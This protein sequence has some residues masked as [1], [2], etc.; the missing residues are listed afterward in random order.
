[1]RPFNGKSQIYP[2]GG[3]RNTVTPGV[4]GAPETVVGGIHD[5]YDTSAVGERSLWTNIGGV[6]NP[7]VWLDFY[8]PYTYSKNTF[9]T[10]RGWMRDPSAYQQYVT[11][12]NIAY[13]SNPGYINAYYGYVHTMAGYN[14]GTSFS[15]G[16]M[17]RANSVV[18]Y[19]SLIGNGWPGGSNYGFEMRR[20]DSG[21]FIMMRLFNVMDSGINI[22]TGPWYYISWTY[23]G[24]VAKAWLNG[25][26][27]FSINATAGIR[28]SNAPVY[29]GFNDNDERWSGDIG[30]LYIGPYVSDDNANLVFEKIRGRFGI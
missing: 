1:M 23:N 28:V 26:L 19:G 17:F 4:W 2:G 21:S 22:A 9:M 8:D 25:V 20:L 27:Q 18:R 3:L 12:G 15:L 14:F 24:S 7:Y 10:S 5:T 11:W 6:I 30:H 29:I 16:M 13:V